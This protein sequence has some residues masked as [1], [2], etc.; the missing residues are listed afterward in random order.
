MR[1]DNY[2][3]LETLN[4]NSFLDNMKSFGYFKTTNYHDLIRFIDEEVYEVFMFGHSCG[5]SDRVMLN[6]IFENHNC[7]AIKLFY[8]K[9]KNGDNFKTLTQDIS[10]HFN[11][12]NEM[13][14]KIIPYDKSQPLPQQM[15]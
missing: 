4:N 13:R 15:N 1:D 7:K 3:R 5:L 14:K 8:H 11:K 10:R 6:M 2:K 9:Y 12:K